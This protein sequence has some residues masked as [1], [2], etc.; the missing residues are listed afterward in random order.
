MSGVFVDNCNV[1]GMIA[2]NNVTRRYGSTAR[3]CKAR[4][5][6]R[7]EEARWIGS[8]KC[9]CDDSIECVCYVFYRRSSLGVSIGTC[10]LIFGIADG[11]LI[12]FGNTL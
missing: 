10:P 9:G 5:C 2:H 8:E 3:V 11:M 7:L 12:V 4:P 6:V 1:C